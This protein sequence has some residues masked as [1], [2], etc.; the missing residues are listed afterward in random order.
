MEIWDLKSQVGAK[1]N[2]RFSPPFLNKIPDLLTVGQRIWTRGTKTTAA[3]YIHGS[4]TPLRSATMYQYQK[5]PLL[6]TFQA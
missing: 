4:N 3:E 1:G 6:R 2:S 5:L